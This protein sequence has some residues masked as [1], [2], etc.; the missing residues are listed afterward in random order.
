MCLVVRLVVAMCLVVVVVGGSSSS[1]AAAARTMP[2]LNPR[3]GT[4]VPMRARRFRETRRAGR[5]TR[6]TDRDDSDSI[7]PGARRSAQPRS[8]IPR[9]AE[10][11]V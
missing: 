8:R 1:S 10:K 9:N 2:R 7:G 11:I 4:D 6:P 5:A 3:C